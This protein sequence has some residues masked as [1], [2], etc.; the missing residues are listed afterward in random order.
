VTDYIL[1]E[2][3]FFKSHFISKT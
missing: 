2:V 1:A 3:L